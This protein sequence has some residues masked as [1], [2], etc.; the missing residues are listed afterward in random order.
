MET[1]GN[2]K[3]DFH[4]T[5]E[6]S[7]SSMVS[8][9]TLDGKRK[10]AWHTGPNPSDTVYY[11]VIFHH[12]GRVSPMPDFLSTSEAW[13]AFRYSIYEIAG[14]DQKKV[15]HIQD[16]WKPIQSQFFAQAEEAAVK[17]EQMDADAADKMLA[18]LLQNISSTIKST[19]LEFNRTLPTWTN[20]IEYV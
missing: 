1:L 11:P 5:R 3:V 16:T 18:T 20:A 6:L 2:P 17:A 19:L 9:F 8:D 15:Q 12:T 10:I 4:G 13:Y 7:A 14:K